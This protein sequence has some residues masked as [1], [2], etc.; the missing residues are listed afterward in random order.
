MNQREAKSYYDIKHYTYS[1][2]YIDATRALRTLY[3]NQVRALE[4]LEKSG[5]TN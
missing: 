1:Q 5:K 4:R 3:Q 2:E